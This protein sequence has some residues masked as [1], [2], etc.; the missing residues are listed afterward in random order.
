MNLHT[1]NLP[2]EVRGLDYGYQLGYVALRAFFKICEDWQAT[3][4]EQGKLLRI[5]LIEL[6]Q[7]RRSPA[8]SLGREQLIRIRCLVMI[9]K[10]TLRRTGAVYR[11]SNILRTPRAEKPF[12]G[13]SPF[14]LMINDGMVGIGSTCKALTGRVPDM[15]S[16]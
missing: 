14:Q 10:D 2:P 6:E 8:T 3:P 1:Q 4:T 13:N 12:S 11:A 9:Y 16:K 15:S 7:L 5:G